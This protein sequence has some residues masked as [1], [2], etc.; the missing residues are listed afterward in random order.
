MIITTLPCHFAVELVGGR[1]TNRALKVVKRTMKDPSLYF[2]Q[3]DYPAGTEAGIKPQGSGVISGIT[4]ITTEAHEE[5]ER[6]FPQIAS[7]YR[8][9]FQFVK[10]GPRPALAFPDNAQYFQV[11]DALLGNALNGM[12]R[13]RHI[14]F[15]LII[16]KEMS[17]GEY[18]SYLNEH[19][20]RK[21]NWQAA[22][23]LIPP[24]EV[25]ASLRAGQFANIFL[26]NNLHE[27]SIGTFIDQHQD[28]LLSALEAQKLVSE[29]YLPWAVPSPDP[30]ETAI[31]P[32]L[33]VQRCDGY[34]DVYDLKLALLNRKNI[35]TGQRN[36][37]RFVNPI[38]EGIAQLAHYREFLAIPEHA[39]LA[40]EKYSVAFNNPRYILIVGN[41]ENVDAAKI[42]DARRRFPDLELIDYDTLLQLY[43]MHKGA[44]TAHANNG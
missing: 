19:V 16:S 5:M 21:D 44:L 37:R 34:W 32:D 8:T 39:A 23:Q 6:R 11:E 4:F 1:R 12:V 2:G 20:V 13:I 41:Y 10:E 3:F 15:A 30:G 27:T 35:T 40:Q 28:V 24:G 31:N 18:R 36:R 7:N 17:P 9:H 22:V 29:P 14:R 43:L 42:A 38:E 26:M 33:F 25:E